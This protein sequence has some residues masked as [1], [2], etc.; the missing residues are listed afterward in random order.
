MLGKIRFPKRNAKA[1]VFGHVH[2]QISEW[3]VAEAHNRSLVRLIRG[4]F[5]PHKLFV[6]VNVSW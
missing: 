3:D 1:T 4:E 5:A 2:I 6:I